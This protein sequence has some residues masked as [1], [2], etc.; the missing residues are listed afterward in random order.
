[1][2]Y[3]Y[4]VV[5]SLV[6]MLLSRHMPLWLLYGRIS[7]GIVRRRQQHGKCLSLACTKV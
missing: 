4:A 7:T 5:M 6:V 1:M 2:L 3:I